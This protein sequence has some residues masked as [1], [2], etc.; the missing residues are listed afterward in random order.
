MRLLGWLALGLAAASALLAG[1]G[2]GTETAGPPVDPFRRIVVT[3]DGSYTAE[4]AGLLMAWKL[5]YFDDVDLGVDLRNPVLP[6]RPIQYVAERSVD[7][8]IS[9]QPQVA[10]AKEKGIPIVAVGNVISRPTAALI[11]LKKSGIERIADLRGKT[12]GFY[13]LSFERGLLQSVLARAG[14][15]LADVKVERVEYETVP[16][17]VNGR[18]DAVIGSWNVEGVKLESRGLHPVVT[19][20]Q[21]LGVPAYDELVV[22]AR[23]DRLRKDPQLISD[24]M[25]AAARGTAAA[26]EDPAA[27]AAAIV[28][29]GEEVD[30]K[31]IEATVEATRPLFSRSGRMSL[32]QAD[33]LVAWMREEGLLQRSLPA[34][35]LLT[36][37]YLPRP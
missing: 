16:A 3:L 21:S 31:A 29:E 32:E 30:R 24:F 8:A 10:L 6:D 22:I 13:G 34:S 27:A 33:R 12:I 36:N 26:I 23:P 2:G 35:V 18:V 11:W 1:C 14:L 17:L 7:L 4:N 37:S 19:R 9:H 28:E 15:T 20:M 25:S 5:G